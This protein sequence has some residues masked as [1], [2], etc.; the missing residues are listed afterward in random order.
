MLSK[1]LNTKDL[2]KD[3]PNTH[4]NTKSNILPCLAL[5]ELVQKKRSIKKSKQE[6]SQ[7]TLLNLPLIFTGLLTFISYGF[8]CRMAGNEIRI[9]N[10]T[11]R[12]L[13]SLREEYYDVVKQDIVGSL[14]EDQFSKPFIPESLLLSRTSDK[15]VLRRELDILIKSHSIR[16]FLLGLE[17]SPG[18]RFFMLEFDFEGCL[19]EI[20]SD[21]VRRFAK[22]VLPSLYSYGI[23]EEAL[24]N[25]K[26]TQ[27]N[28]REL[29]KKGVILNQRGTYLLHVPAA[30]RLIS[31]ISVG[32]RSLINH[33][34]KSPRGIM[35]QKQ[36]EQQ[37]VED[38]IFRSSYILE[39]LVGLGICE[40][41]KGTTPKVRLVVNP[42][43]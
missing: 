33:L 35:E 12:L 2:H 16:Q 43:A 42:Y 25:K 22:E 4:C 13:V 37:D 7:N 1:Q 10:G 17:E 26:F 20:N 29:L 18:E 32:R 11:H 40:M 31:S 6:Q 24:N 14:R 21:V 8:V 15:R 19:N 23:T 38:S 3:E 28:I 41:I 30:G 34:R 9:L 39:T 5:F 36:L 27:D